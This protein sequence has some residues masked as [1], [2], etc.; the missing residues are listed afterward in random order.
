MIVFEVCMPA[1][2]WIAPEMPTA[3][4]SWG[5]T[6]LPVWPTWNWCGY[7]PASVAARDA[8]TAAPTES[9]S[10]SISV[11]FSAPPTPR[12]PETTMAAS[13]SS[14]RSS[15]SCTTRSVMCAALAA[16]L[17]STATCSSSAGPGAGSAAAEFGRTAT[18]GVPVRTR[19]CTT[20]APPKMDC[21]ASRP[22]P[23]SPA[24]RPTASVITPAR[25]G[26][27]PP[28]AP[29]A[30]DGLLREQARAILT[31]SQAHRVG[32]H[33]RAG[34]DRQPPGDLL[35]LRRRGHE[36]RR[37]RMRGDQCREHLG[38]GRY[39]V[40]IE[41]IAVSDVD[42][43]RAELGQPLPAS[44]RAGAQPDGRGLTE[45]AG[46]GEQLAGDLLDLLARM[47][48]EDEDLSHG[49]QPLQLS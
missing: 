16:S 48:G 32:D 36:H 23:S 3:M 27:G 34:L 13:V 25:G 45:R 10:F 49:R 26:G 35:A 17:T 31:G 15:R 9:A 29:P 11:K 42:L 30:E 20:I 8:P 19:D 4:W 7:Q 21:S 38:L 43:D 1:R 2:C 22:V 33:A 41:I 6:V 5:E 40:V 39:H 47:L 44:L 18:M 37:G 46:E 14:G 28:A 24:A 12:P